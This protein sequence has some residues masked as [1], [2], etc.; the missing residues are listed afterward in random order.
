MRDSKVDNMSYSHNVVLDHGTN[1]IK[2][3]FSTQ[4]APSCVIPTVVGRGRHKGAMTALGLKDTYIGAGAQVLRGILDMSNPIRNGVVNSWDDLEAIWDHV[5]NTELEASPSD[6]PVVATLP[7]LSAPTD[8]A[9][10]VEILMEKLN[11]PAVYLANKSVLAL[12][13]GGQMTGIAVDSGYDTSYIVPSYQGIPIQDA[14]LVLKLGG[15]H[16]T[17]HLMNQLMNGKYSF[18][19]DNFLLWRKKKKTKF[20]VSSKREIIREMKEQHCFVTNTYEKSIADESF[21]EKSI[22]LPDGNMI[23]MGREQFSAPEI[24]FKPSLAN[25]KSC[26]LDELIYYSVMKCDESLRGELLNNITLS[27]GNTKFPG[28]EKRL[29]SELRRLLPVGTPVKIR[30]LPNR[31]HM[32]WVGGARLSSLSSFQS[33]WMSRA[34]YK[35]KGAN[36]SMEKGISSLNLK[37][38]AA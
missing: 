2:A 15:K 13:G 25:K 33:M 18:P 20:T 5:Y 28:F 7:P 12:F 6:L 26:G 10:M 38:E 27:G 24:L 30:A 17:D 11:A 35:E 14:T 23:V 32:T 36:V 16:V 4:D 8:S 37:T 9:K 1:T 19:D 31:E 3:G 22:R 29:Y 34:E 21:P